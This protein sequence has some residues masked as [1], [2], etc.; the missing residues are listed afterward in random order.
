M[1]TLVESAAYK[2]PEHGF[3]NQ[4]YLTDRYRRR[5]INGEDVSTYIHKPDGR[6]VPSKPLS[7]IAES[8]GLR[9]FNE[10]PTGKGRWELYAGMNLGIPN[11]PEGETTVS[12]A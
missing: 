6:W 11:F 12:S 10:L 8:I 7:A 4:S 9:R 3:L 2:I 5:S 1:P